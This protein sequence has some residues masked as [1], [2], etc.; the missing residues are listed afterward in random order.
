MSG[1]VLSKVPVLGRF[2]DERFL[3]H[4]QRSTSA[5][6]IVG[7]LVALVLAEYRIFHDHVVPWDLIAVVASIVVVKMGLMVWF[8]WKD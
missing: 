3:E 6:G 2:V 7:A 4:R 1:S 5:A 8:R